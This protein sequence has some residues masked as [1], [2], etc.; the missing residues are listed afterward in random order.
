LKPEIMPIDL[1]VAYL[2]HCLGTDDLRQ[3]PPHSIDARQALEALWPL[4]TLFIGRQREL[5][6]LAYDPAAEGEAD[7]A[8]CAFILM[9]V[10]ETLAPLSPAGWRVLLE[11]HCQWLTE[12]AVREAA[13][14]T[15]PVARLP[16]ALD[17]EQRKCALVARLYYR[18]RLPLQPT[19]QTLLTLP[20]P[21]HAPPGRLQ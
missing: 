2:S 3:H 7:D 17:A 20:D 18:M 14:I 5:Q 13:S 8:I 9:P 1:M 16:A 10:P 21:V 19:E 4:N 6:A 15:D 12:L 11:R